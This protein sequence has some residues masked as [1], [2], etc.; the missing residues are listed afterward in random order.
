MAL[1][2]SQLST[3]RRCPRQ[4]EYACVKKVSRPMSEGESFGSSLHSTLRKFGLLELSKAKPEGKKQLTLFTEDHTHDQKVELSLT[5]L[6]S[7]WRES[8][9]AEGYASHAEMD[10]RFAEGEK[11]LT[12]YFEWWGRQPRDV[13]AIEKGF[14]FE[15]PDSKDLVFSGRFDRVERTNQGLRVIDYKSTGPRDETSLLTDLQLSVYAIAAAD[16]WKEPV[17]SLAILSVTGN[18]CIE[19]TTTR[20]P[21]QLRDALKSIRILSERIDAK[22][23]TATP[24]KN[25]C[26]TCPYRDICPARAV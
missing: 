2:Y 9:I 17:E 10:Q 4:Y 16:L 5:T 7:L 3:Y 26:R 23:F 15:I 24:S 1:S 11:V 25:V 14:S 13:V 20:T 6:L 8:F 22:D 18:G 19:Q 21:S 12:H